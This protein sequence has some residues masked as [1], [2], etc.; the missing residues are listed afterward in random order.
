MSVFWQLAVA[1]SGVL[2][3]FFLRQYAHVPSTLPSQPSEGLSLPA[4]DMEEG[5]LLS[6]A[7]LGAAKEK[8]P[9]ESA[10]TR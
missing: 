4:G 8:G 7:Q 1:G 9:P 5:R 6:L 2:A 10:P 3:L